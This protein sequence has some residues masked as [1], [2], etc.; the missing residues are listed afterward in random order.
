VVRRIFDLYLNGLSMRRIVFQLTKEGVPTKLDRSPI[1]GRKASSAGTWRTSAVHG[2][3]SNETYVGTMH[4]NK[5]QHG[6]DR[7]PMPR[8]RADWLT[9]PVPAI[10][11]QDIFDAARDKRARNKS[12]S[13][14]NRRYEYLFLGGRLRCGRCHLGMIGY[15]NKGKLYYRCASAYRHHPDEPFCRGSVR[16]V[17]IEPPVWQAIERVL[18]DPAIIMAELD[19]REHQG[20]TL[21]RDMT[22]ERQGLQKA[23]TAL[24]REAHRWDEAYAQEVID[25]AELKEKNSTSPSVNSG[26]SPSKRQSRQLCNRH[27][28]PKPRHGI[29]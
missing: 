25:I 11:T 15:P 18:S 8:D 10:V 28:S 22:K 2:V 16:V 13:L 23:L 12:L 19:H 7:P 3:L 6:A 9:I 14:R 1:P 29:F 17:D 4:W 21:Q 5:Y 26:C 24:E 27:S 20:A